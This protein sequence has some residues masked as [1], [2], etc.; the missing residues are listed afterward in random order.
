MQPHCACMVKK[1]S[2]RVRYAG[3]SSSWD[4]SSAPGLQQWRRGG[5]QAAWGW[6][7]SGMVPPNLPPTPAGRPTACRLAHQTRSVA[8]CSQYSQAPN[9][10]TATISSAAPR[11]QPYVTVT[12]LWRAQRWR[13]TWR[14]PKSYTC[15]QGE[16][17]DAWKARERPRKPQALL[18]RP[19]G[20]IRVH[21]A[22]RARSGSPAAHVAGG[23]R[24]LRHKL[25][26]H[27]GLLGRLHPQLHLPLEHHL[28]QRQRQGRGP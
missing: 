16:R 1:G 21:A 3:Y 28:Q 9:S 25:A 26:Q 6:A 11:W 27:K 22:P 23:P 2:W 7:P 17:R 8:T 19:R 24:L 4:S 14:S 13:P 15:L 12:R 20:V 5:R 18:E 10:D